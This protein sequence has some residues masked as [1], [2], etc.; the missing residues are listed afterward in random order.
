MSFAEGNKAVLALEN[1]LRLQ[2]E[3]EKADSVTSVR[4]AITASLAKSNTIFFQPTLVEQPQEEPEDTIAS[5]VKKV[6]FDTQGKLNIIFEDDSKVTS[7][8]ATPADYIEQHVAVQVNPVFDYVRF[9]T[10]FLENSTLL[11]EEGLLF[12]DKFSHSLS[13]YNDDSGVVLNIGQE[14]ILRVYNNT[15][16]SLLNGKVAYVS[17]AFSGFPTVELASCSSKEQ[18]YAVIGVV[19]S[20]I[21][22]YG[23]GYVCVDGTVNAVDTSMYAAGDTIYLSTAAGE[24]TN[25]APVQPNYVVIVGKILLSDSTNGKLH[26]KIDRRQWHANLNLLETT[27]TIVLPTVPTPIKPSVVNRIEG[28][29]Y[30]P[31]TGEITFLESDSYTLTIQLNATPSASNKNIYFYS[32]EYYE[33]VWT[34]NRN[35]ARMVRMVN[36]VEDQV[37][38]IAARYVKTGT[39]FRFNVWSD[40]TVS[41]KST[42]LP[43]TVPGTV[44][45]PAIR[46]TLA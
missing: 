21:P 22:A 27:G 41:L 4:D 32:E 31:A 19:T 33:G 43:G 42:D 35:T 26:V 8:N 39:K 38:I 24:I 20:D 37:N 25:I 29:E 1:K 2:Q 45:I 11:H 28:F 9:N 46:L 7:T 30:N 13:Y 23:Y 44:T 3:K 36:Q 15:P 18:S 34:I 12:Y 14:Q 6:Y 10:E 5:S 16:T 40:P 17:G